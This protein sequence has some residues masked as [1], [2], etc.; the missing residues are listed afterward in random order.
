MVF[1]ECISSDLVRHID[2]KAEPLVLQNLRT[3]SR[4]GRSFFRRCGFK[5]YY[6]IAKLSVGVTKHKMRPSVQN[7]SR[8]DK[9][10]LQLHFFFFL[11]FEFSHWLGHTE[12]LR[13]LYHS[14]PFLILS[15]DINETAVKLILQENLMRHFTSNKLPLCLQR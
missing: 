3:L 4:R 6:I 2:L 10:I 13:S 9:D 14:L 11:F 12:N 7:T 15:P 5:D 8:K 1:L